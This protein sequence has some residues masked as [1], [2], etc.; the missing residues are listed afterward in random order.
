MN[1]KSST[2]SSSTESGGSEKSNV[3]LSSEKSK[4]VQK[5]VEN[6]ENNYPD[7]TDTDT[8][9][10]EFYLFYIKQSLVLYM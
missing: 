2:P 3:S 8:D 1:K 4:A 9:S 5:V 10:K 7:T 6:V